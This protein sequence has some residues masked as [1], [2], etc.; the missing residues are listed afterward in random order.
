MPVTPGP[1]GGGGGAGGLTLGPAP[2]TFTAATRAAAEALR[3]AESAAWLAEY[4]AEPTFTI[5]LNWP[6]TPTNTIYQARRS[7]SW[8]DVTG[9][10]RGP[11]GAASTVPG[12]AGAAGTDGT[13][14][15][16]GT[17]GTDGAA[18]TDGTDGTDRY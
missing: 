9:L 6:A 13:D 14:G 1:G 11:R 3:D 16:A 8:A 18:G 10:V 7:S 4:D 17:D 2:N 15:A 5:T 12:P